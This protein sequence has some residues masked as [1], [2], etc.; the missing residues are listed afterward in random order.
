M[1]RIGKP[2]IAAALL[3]FGGQVQAASVLILNGNGASNIAAPIT[4]AGFTVISD[5]FNPGVIA[6]RLAVPN[7]ISQIWIWNDGSFGGSFSAAVP[8]RAFNAADLAALQTFNGTRDNWIMD[9]LSWRG[10]ANTDERNFTMNQALALE[11]AGGGIVLGADDASG[12]AIVQ[13]V[14]Q[15]AAF[16]NF[17]LFGGVYN[18]S[19]ASQQFGGSFISSPNSVNPANVVGTTTYSEM[20]N[21]LQPN[22]IFM[23]TAVFGIGAVNNCCGV[24]V[25]AL[26]SDT[27]NGIT[28]QS[29]NHVVTTN[30]PGAGINPPP[31]P[32]TGAVPEPAT[33]AMMIMGF[34]AIGGAL[35]RR[36][37]MRVRYA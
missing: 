7:D 8:A 10:N 12:A 37:A 33:W 19:P 16:F 3:A 25:P 32:P 29:V 11:A 17:N 14:N 22:G 34:G 18:T 4:T 26:G 31:P 2:A 1:T 24:P 35:R 23:A 5:A 21:G 9:G 13:H 36:P 27:F 15:V 30:I 6:S 20:P 28:H